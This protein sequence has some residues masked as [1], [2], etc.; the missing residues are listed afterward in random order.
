MTAIIKVGCERKWWRSVP[1]HV[2]EILKNLMKDTAFLT[3]IQ[4]SSF[5]ETE[6]KF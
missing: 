3:K 2:Q 1:I 5:L 6:Y 4:T